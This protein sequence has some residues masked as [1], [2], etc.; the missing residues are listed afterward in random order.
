MGCDIHMYVQYRDK[1]RIGTKH[2]WWRDF[3][4]RLSPGRNY[5]M[6]SIL[7]MGVRG[8]A[9]KGF[10]PKGL[11]DFE[12]GW[13]AEADL[14]LYITEDGKEEG[15]CTL[16]QAE[17]WRRPIIK[18]KEGK[19]TKTLHPDWHSHSWLTTKELAQAYRWYKK[20]QNYDVGLNIGSY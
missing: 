5:N 6:F 11:P 17:S 13:G 4:G 9:V 1:S 20:E 8:E 15:S 14:Y 12:L 7:S 18:N 10:E 16:A 19:P 2:S 3:A